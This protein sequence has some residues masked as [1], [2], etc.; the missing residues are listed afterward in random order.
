MKQKGIVFLPLLI[1][2]FV[3]LATVSAIVLGTAIIKDNINLEPSPSVTPTPIQCPQGW[4]STEAGCLELQKGS[5]TPTIF[6]VKQQTNTS[7]T[8][9][10]N[11]SRTGSI[12][13]YKEYC[14]GKEISVYANEIFTKVS[15]FD[16]KTYSM[17]QGD[18]DCYSKNSQGKSANID[19]SSSPPC[20]VYYNILKLTRTYTGL[21]SEECTKLKNDA[22]IPQANNAQLSYTP[23][24]LPT[25][26]PYQYSQE[27]TDSINNFN[28]EVSK[29]YQPSQF[30]APTPRCYASWTEY[31]NA[32]PSYSS[33]N[34]T[35]VGSP[36][37]D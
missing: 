28:Q 17:T 27:Y 31:F 14:S 32:H 1:W 35:Q 25:Y 11:G 34:I 37:C 9:T 5:D 6:P 21:S 36:P 4:V 26:P 10:N 22:Y 8:N 7:Q 24:P 15:P 12:I 3:G 18:W 29:P 23:A 20:T 33:N 16:G 2:S 30:T 19:T 13:S